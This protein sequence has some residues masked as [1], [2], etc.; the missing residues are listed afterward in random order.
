MSKPISEK[1]LKNELSIN[2]WTEITKEKLLKF[3]ELMPKLDKDVQLSVLNQIPD[4]ANISREAITGIIEVAKL[5]KDITKSTLSNL[6]NIA[7]YLG[8]FSKN[9]NLT[10]DERKYVIDK[11]MEVAI[12][13]KVIFEKDH[14]FWVLVIKYLGALAGF[15]LIMITYALVGGG[16]SKE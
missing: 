13:T 11:L 5:K 1:E 6:E 9:E 7:S 12:I 14:D 10:L 4:L 16:K 15:V 2:N 3:I 8:S